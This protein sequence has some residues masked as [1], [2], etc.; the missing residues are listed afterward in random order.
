MVALGASCATSDQGKTSPGTEPQITLA[1]LPGTAFVQEY[2]GPFTIGF[3]MEV[4]NPANEEIELKGVELEAMGASPY[5]L[6]SSLIPFDETI[7]PGEREVVE[8]SMSAY[9]RGGE[10]SAKAP[11]TIRG[12]VQFKRSAGTFQKV[13]TQRIN[14][15]ASMGLY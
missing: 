7:G 2:Q 13:F 1:Q 3:A 9:S 12:V 5:R 14:Q 10:F 4:T 8:F 6:Q 11:V 15:P